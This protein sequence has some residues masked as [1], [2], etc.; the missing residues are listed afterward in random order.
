MTQRKTLSEEDKINIIVDYN[1]LGASWSVIGRK[2][3]INPN[4][5]RTFINRYKKNHTISHK[6]GRPIEITAEIKDAVIGVTE[7]DPEISLR[8]ISDIFDISTTS[9]RS[10]LNEDGIKYF[11][12]IPVPPLTPTHMQN[13]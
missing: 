8:D 2:R 9:A 5:V 3:G 1:T 6:M 7:A 11:Q 12:K 4:T 13:R 10:A